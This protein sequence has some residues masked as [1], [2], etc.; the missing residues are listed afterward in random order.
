MDAKGNKIGLALSGGGYRAAA[1]HIGTLRALQKLKILDKVDVISSVSGGSIISA[2]YLLH[3][4]NYQEFEKSISRKLRIGVLHLAIANLFA[5]LAGIG[6]LIYFVGWWTLLLSLILLWFSNYYILP[7]SIWIEK[8][9]NWLFF[10]NA[11][12]SDLPQTPAI[13]INTTDVAK[14]RSFRFS[15]NKAWGYDYINKDDQLDVFSGENFPL[16]KAV[17]ASSC[18]PFA[19]SPIRI[20]EKYKRY[21]HYKCPLLV[22]GGLYDN[23]GTYELTESSD[24][25]MHAKYIIVS[26]AGNTELTDQWITNIP[27]MLVLTSNILMKRIERMQ[28]RYNMFETDNVKR[29]IA[30]IALSYEI[31]DRIIIG[32]VRGIKKGNVSEELYTYH[33]I[34]KD[35][36]QKIKRFYG[37]NRIEDKKFIEFIISKVKRSILWDDLEKIKPS[38]TEIKIA[39][40]VGTNLIGLS[41]QKIESLI[42]FAE[43]MATVQIR[44][45]LPNLLDV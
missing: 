18:V 20:P 4:E 37:S 10:K 5:V 45:Y 24:K 22:D 19:F 33:S 35:D 34:T 3:K 39:K 44:L 12:L 41:P 42:K 8:Q 14:G 11:T 23:Q 16:A 6:A 2:Y 40:K 36:A 38:S 13:S 28:S 32:F 21:N 26:N 7:V 9:Y 43:W 25:D 1:Y 27:L 15:R 30:N 31:S 17:M 29:R